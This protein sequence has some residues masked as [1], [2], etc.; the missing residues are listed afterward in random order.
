MINEKWENGKELTRHNARRWDGQGT[1]PVRDYSLVEKMSAL[2]QPRMLSGMR[3]AFDKHGCIPTE[4]PV[5]WGNTIFYQAI[6]ANAK[7]CFP[8]E[9]KNPV[10]EARNEYTYS[11]AGQ[12][13]KLVQKWN[14]SYS[15][16]PVG[17]VSSPINTS[18]LTSSKKTE[19]T[20]LL[21]KVTYPTGG[22]TEIGYEY[23]RY[24]YYKVRGLK[25]I[26]F[27]DNISSTETPCGGARVLSI[28]DY[29]PVNMI[30]YLNQKKNIF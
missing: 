27:V 22:T 23:N 9:K 2:T 6:L 28:K 13:L 24:R 3:P 14:P 29:D 1:N 4:C 16:T 8:T 10:A 11:A 25:T 21:N 5:L 20:G 15:P 19:Y 18:S 26:K 7:R 17:G 30:L 12:K